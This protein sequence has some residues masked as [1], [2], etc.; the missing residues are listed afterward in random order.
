[1]QQLPYLANTIVVTRDKYSGHVHVDRQGQPQLAY[2]LHA[3]DAQHLL[4]GI[5]KALRIH[6]AA[7]ADVIYGPNN[8]CLSYHH[9][10]NGHFE[11]FL[12]RIRQAGSRPNHFGLF[13]AHQMSSCRISDSPQRGAVNP[14]GE[15]Y[16][17]RDLF[18][19]D[20]SVL[21]TATGVNPMLTILA[22]AH[23]LAQR[24]KARWPT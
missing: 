23:H 11:S 1:M 4:V 19:A 18:V 2:R 9:D 7:G 13:C 14:D 5:E 12:K 21:P 17:V 20:G 3:Y 22:T 24:I 15:T 6:R 16:D 10:E 8:D